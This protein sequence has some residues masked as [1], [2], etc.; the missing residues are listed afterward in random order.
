MRT[1]LIAALVLL[2][3]AGL[4]AAVAAPGYYYPSI[5]DENRQYLIAE[6]GLSYDA[7]STT[8][9]VYG[10]PGAL[11][12]ATVTLAQ[13]IEIRLDSLDR[14][15]VRLATLATQASSAPPTWP[16][17]GGVWFHELGWKEAGSRCPTVTHVPATTF[18]PT[19]DSLVNQLTGTGLTTGDVRVGTFSS[20]V[21]EH[22]TNN[23]QQTVTSTI[24]YWSNPL[25]RNLGNPPTSTWPYMGWTLQAGSTGSPDY[26]EFE[27]TEPTAT[28]GLVTHGS[29]AML[30]VDRTDD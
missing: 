12:D 26:I 10:P 16:L 11:T 7:T 23:F 6:Y 15:H 30:N 28:R 20:T 18:D 22:P 19:L 3:A 27:C 21:S 29:F 13:A 1:P 14:N 17:Q 25:D 2:A 5:R 4:H 8:R 24:Q 9:V